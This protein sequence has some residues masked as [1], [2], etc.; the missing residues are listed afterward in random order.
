MESTRNRTFDRGLQDECGSGTFRAE[1]GA[2][3]A[4][5]LA[6]SPRRRWSARPPGACRKEEGRM[7]NAELVGGWRS[8]GGRQGQVPEATE[9][10]EA[11]RVDQGQSNQIRPNQTKSDQ[12]RP[13]KTV[14]PGSRRRPLG[15][16]WRERASISVA[17]VGCGEMPAGW[18]GRPTALSDRNTFFICDT[19]ERGLGLEENLR[20]FSLIL[21]Y[22][23]LIGKKCLRTCADSFL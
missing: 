3:S 11:N 1:W 9:A 12:I 5:I 10:T 16:N 19:D 4:L 15:Q 22:H 6:F 14:R 7:Q 21:A 8:G 13:K 18:M 20:L 2:Y 17:C 23:R